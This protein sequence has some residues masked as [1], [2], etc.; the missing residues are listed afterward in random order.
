MKKYLYAVAFAAV[1]ISA[2]ATEVLA[3]ARP[4]DPGAPP[5][6]W[7]VQVLPIAVMILV[8]Y[9]FLRVRNFLTT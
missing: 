8:F 6:P 5:P 4:A 1:M 9:F 7:W 2:Q 3:M